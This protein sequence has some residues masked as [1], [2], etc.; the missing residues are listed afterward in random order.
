MG[1]NAEKRRE[2]ERRSWDNV[3]GRKLP[4]MSINE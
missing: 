1:G 2:R 4:E 3:M